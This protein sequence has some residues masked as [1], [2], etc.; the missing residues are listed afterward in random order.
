MD[1]IEDEADDIEE[2]FKKLE[3]S[4]WAQKYDVAF[5]NLGKTQEAHQVGAA[6]EH[7]E[8]S[9]EGEALG[10]ELHDLDMALKKHVKVT[11]IPEEWKEDMFLF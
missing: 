9:P 4:H 10:K 5:H 11:D 7:F 1:D 3:K 6:F 8:E 2:E